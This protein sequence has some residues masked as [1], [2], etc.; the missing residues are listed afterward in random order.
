MNGKQV[1]YQEKTLHAP[2]GLAVLLINIVLMFATVAGIVYSAMQLVHDLPMLAALATAPL[3][4]ALLLR[5]SL[6]V[7][8]E[9]RFGLRPALYDLAQ[10]FRWWRR[11]WQRF[12]YRH[13]FVRKQ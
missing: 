11:K 12:R 8:G 13:D 3:M 5:G 1:E 6:N 7:T 4:P 2:N 9:K 10:P